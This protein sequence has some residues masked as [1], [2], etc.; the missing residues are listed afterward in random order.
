MDTLLAGGIRITTI[1]SNGKLVTEE[2]LDKLEERGIYPEFNM[3]Y[4]GVDGWHDWLRGIDG[5]GQIAEEAF[6]R[7]KKR[8]FR[9]VLKC[10]FTAAISICFVKRLKN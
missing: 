10:A 2:L 8:G 1:Y 6:L 7:R 4:D 9:Q 5:A 3:S